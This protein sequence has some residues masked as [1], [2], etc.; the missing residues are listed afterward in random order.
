MRG[1]I[2]S[3]LLI[4]PL[5]LGCGGTGTPA[6]TLASQGVNRC[7]TATDA[8]SLQWLVGCWAGE[9][10]G[11]VTTER[12]RLAADGW[13]LGDNRTMSGPR[14]VHE[15]RMRIQ[16]E[17]DGW[18]YQAAPQG[19]ADATF[20]ASAIGHH[21]VDFAAPTHDYPQRIG[22]RLVEAGQ[23][24]AFIAGEQQGDAKSKVWHWQRAD[25]AAVR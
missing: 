14:L 23:L 15:E 5:W 18:H 22:Y 16:R 24:T 21:C 7:R 12:W 8:T 25:C 2:L 9:Q 4:S 6:A 17:A 3:L 10:N 11:K 20:S 19:Q 1:L 13:L